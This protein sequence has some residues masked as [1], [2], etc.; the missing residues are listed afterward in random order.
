MDRSVEY[1]L[2]IQYTACI[3]I[4]LLYQEVCHQYWPAACGN[5]KEKYGDLSVETTQENKYDGYTER[6]LSVTD[7]VTRLCYCCD[8]DK[9]YTVCCIFVVW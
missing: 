5:D 6:I 1:Q 3:V 7:K 2:L 9:H 4:H 8:I